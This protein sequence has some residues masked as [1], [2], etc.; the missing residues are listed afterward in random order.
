MNLPMI[1][2]L[3]VTRNDRMALLKQAIGDFARQIFEP[4]ELVIVHDGG[5]ARQSE[6]EDLSRTFMPVMIRAICQPRGQSLGTLRNAALDAARGDWVCQWDDD[7]RYH[8]RR[9]TLQ[10]DHLT[11]KSAAAGFL[12]DQLHWFTR[13]DELF[14][15]DWDVE[16]FPMNVIQGTM[17]AHRSFMPR[18]A[19][20]PRGEDT[21]LT[22]A[23]LR[24]AAERGGRIAR[25]RDVGWC[26]I[27]RQHGANVWDE[28]HH[29]AISYLKHIRASRLLP[30]IPVLQQRLAEFTPALPPLRLKTG[31]DLV[32]LNPSG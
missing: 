13:T 8:P 1:S 10:W 29:R 15:D 30:L 31:R 24:A 5:P 27:Y 16:P 7:D 9:L 4:R 21:A 22:V 11:E 32:L 18:Y 20:M 25:L 14:W 28:Q 12:V 6:I 2:C 23:M 17:L 19:D 26:Y 3:C